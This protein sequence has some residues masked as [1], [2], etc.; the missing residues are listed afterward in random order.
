MI[1]HRY[2][3]LY[4][5]FCICILKFKGAVQNSESNCHTVQAK[6]HFK[7]KVALMSNTRKGDVYYATKQ[8][9]GY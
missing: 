5:T 4:A 1:T 3:S 9:T 6:F 8:Q 7:D 2:G